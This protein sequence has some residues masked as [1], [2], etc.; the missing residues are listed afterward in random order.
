MG[1]ENNVPHSYVNSILQVLYSF[2]SVRNQALR[3]QVSP[4]HHQ[5]ANQYTLWCEL[6]FLFHMLQQTECQIAEDP[7]CENIEKMVRPANFQ[8]TF[9]TYQLLPEV[10]AMGLFDPS[11]QK[12]QQLLIQT[13]TQFILKH[14]TKEL[15]TERK[16]SPAGGGGRF[17]SVLDQ[18]FG[19]SVRSSTTFLQS[20]TVKVD[21]TTARLLYVEAV[22][23][24]LT[25]KQIIKP[26]ATS[27]VPAKKVSR[28]FAAVLWGSLQ[29]ESFMK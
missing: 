18:L 15:E 24:S 28:S 16:A 14:L 9:Q 19:F 6:G 13:F 1:L 3:S 27:P 7:K 21:P 17:D 12:D 8:R 10:A 2:S 22:Y 29:K 11:V 26:G 4:Y 25:V 20:G 23:P 5:E